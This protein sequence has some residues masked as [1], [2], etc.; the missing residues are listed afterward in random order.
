MKEIYTIEIIQK[1]IDTRKKQ[2]HDV[3]SIKLVPRGL[4]KGIYRFPIEVKIVDHPTSTYLTAT[5]VVK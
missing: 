4:T 3:K 2:W 5:F 1:M